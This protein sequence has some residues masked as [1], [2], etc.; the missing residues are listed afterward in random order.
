MT[1]MKQ[2]RYKAVAG[3]YYK[4][5]KEIWGFRTKAA[6]GRPANRARDFLKANRDLFG[7]A[8]I[9]SR[10]KLQRKIESLGAR[11]LI[12]QQ[13]HLGLRIHRAYVTVH[14]D[15][16][17]RIYM[18]KNRAVPA[19]FLPPK[20]DPKK[21]K[22]LLTR[23]RARRRAIRSVSRGGKNCRV[24]DVEKLWYPEE[25]FLR[26]A[27]R[28]RIHRLQ[29]YED[30]IVYIDA[31]KGK[32]LNKYDNLAMR[33]A[34]A[35]VFDPNPVVALNDW[36][37]LLSEDGKPKR[38]PADVYRTVTLRNLKGTGYLEG[39][40]VTTCRTRNRIKRPDLRF[41][42]ESTEA[43]FDEA[44]VYFHIDRAVE[45]LKSLGY[46]GKRAIFEKAIEIN[47][48]GTRKDNSWY[49][50]GLKRLTFGTGGVD[51]AEDAETILHEFGHALQDAICPDFGQSP[52]A[53]AMGE[54]F[55]D[56]FAASFFEEYKT[57]KE[58]RVS[59]SSWDQITDKEFEPPCLR[60][61]NLPMT[62]ENFDNAEDADEHQNGKIWSATL[63]DV[64]ERFGRDIADRIIIESHFQLDG[65]TKFA[66]A[67]RAI[68]DAD[69]NLYRGRHVVALRRI[70][71][72]RGIGPVE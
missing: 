2:G 71:H 19:E 62:F 40:H 28:V 8:G 30:W 35:R 46:R 27:F 64:R 63:W 59:I 41:D 21:S 22:F 58:L 72:A 10:I 36:K 9:S 4:T 54:G 33:R 11:H 29:P 48:H 57:D 52:E 43:G 7:L 68:I 55:G 53:A 3:Y 14:M 25:K 24:L 49:S 61:V 16:K 69:R 17:N 39:A 32:L 56:Y 60:R 70:F 38:P 26:P 67:A 6:R 13:S 51:D 31:R 44:M 65:F 12:F 1:P 5:P 66:R 47:A 18:A 42:F 15:L 34:M 50:P 23:E 37:S 45:Y 20:L